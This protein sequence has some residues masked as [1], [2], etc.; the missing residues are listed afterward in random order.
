MT[1]ALIAEIE[2]YASV[3]DAPDLNGDIVAPGAFA[4]SLKKNRK[5]ALLYQHAVEAPIGR[6]LC[7]RGSCALGWRRY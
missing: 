3:F 4:K 2:G 1:H 5:P 6:W 7:A